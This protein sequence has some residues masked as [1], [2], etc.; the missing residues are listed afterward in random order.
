MR[1]G[2][3]VATV[4]VGDRGRAVDMCLAYKTTNTINTVDI[5]PCESQVR[6]KAML[7]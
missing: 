1:G 2:E 4:V 3:V 6:A 7:E 5:E